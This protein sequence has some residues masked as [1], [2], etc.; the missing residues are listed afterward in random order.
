MVPFPHP[1]VN[2]IL[3]NYT[4]IP[5]LQTKK[6]P[7]FTLSTTVEELQHTITLATEHASTAEG[8]ALVM[9]AASLV[10]EL[11]AWV[12]DKSQGDWGELTRCKAS[13]S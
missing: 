5:R 3:I 4:A 12:S 10:Q 13:T 9:T 11:Y 6:P 8:R 1:S 7:S 2:D